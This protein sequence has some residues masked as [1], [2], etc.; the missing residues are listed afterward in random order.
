[1]SHY[2]NNFLKEPTLYYSEVI[3][4]NS[5]TLQ[6]GKGDGKLKKL[7]R[8]YDCLLILILPILFVVL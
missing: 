2:I 8:N 5:I 3:L 4:F 7:M 1:M 6:F